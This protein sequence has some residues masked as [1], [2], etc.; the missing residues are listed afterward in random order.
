MMPKKKNTLLRVIDCYF[1][2]TDSRRLTSYTM[3]VII[4]TT[5]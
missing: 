4:N 1:E 2:T 5:D 3:L